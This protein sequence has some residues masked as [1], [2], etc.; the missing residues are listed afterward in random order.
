MI[1]GMLIYLALFLIALWGA[2]CVVMII[3]R[4]GQKRFKSEEQQLMFLEALEAPLV[5]GDFDT[6]VEVCEGDRRAMCQLAQLALVNRKAGYSK[7]KQMVLERFQRD[8]LA[9]LEHRL[10]WVNTVIKSA[11]MVGL[12][13]TVIGMMGAFASLAGSENVD[14]AVL[15]KDI[16][17]ALITTACGLAIA[18][19]L[20]LCTTSINVRIRNLEDLV[21]AGLTQFF[22]TFRNSISR[23][24]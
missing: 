5:N 8:V 24:K 4:V 7:V 3:M 18:I 17:F 20:V 13:G 23:S 19:P 2:F 10:S 21:A 11:P 22:E 1:V 15:A 14:P 9:D 12:L 6:A 16:Q